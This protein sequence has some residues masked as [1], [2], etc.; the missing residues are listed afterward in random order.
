ML[1]KVKKRLLPKLHQNPVSTETPNTEPTD[2]KY[3]G[4]NKVE[5]HALT[6]K[7]HKRYIEDKIRSGEKLTFE[8]TFA[9]NRADLRNPLN[10]ANIPAAAGAGYVDFLTDTV[11][12]IPGVNIPKLPKYESAT[13]QG[14]RQM[15]NIIIPTLSIGG[16]L[17][18]RRSTGS[19]KSKIGH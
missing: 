10:W 6:R 2:D 8:D 17:K 18:R 4:Y 14:I 1:T 12:L 3:E 7:D 16:L 9:H 19:L 11:N 5:G 15:S 13:L